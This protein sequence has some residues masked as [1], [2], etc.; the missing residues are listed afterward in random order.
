LWFDPFSVA[1]WFA[2]A[3]VKGEFIVAA[4]K[5]ESI[6]AIVK[7]RTPRACYKLNHMH[8]GLQPTQQVWV[9]NA[10]LECTYLPENESTM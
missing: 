2:V 3:T 7:K 8:T 1:I 4:A 10:L 5:E 6:V 9:P